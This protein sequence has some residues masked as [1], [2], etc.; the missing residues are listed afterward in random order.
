MELWRLASEQFYSRVSGILIGHSILIAV[1]GQLII[2]DKGQIPDYITLIIIIVGIL[3][4]FVWAYFLY[5]SISAEGQYRKIVEEVDEKVTGLK[6]AIRGCYCGLR[7]IVALS[8]LLFLSIYVATL[9]FWI[10]G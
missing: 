5:Q 3:L 6:I 7:A 2:N 10:K 4:C 8:V 1:I 9:I